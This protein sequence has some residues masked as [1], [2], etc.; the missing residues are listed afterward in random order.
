MQCVRRWAEHYRRKKN[1]QNGTMVHFQRVMTVDRFEIFEGS[2]KKWQAR[3][4]A[5]WRASGHR[6]RGWINDRKSPIIAWLRR[7]W[8]T[9]VLHKFHTCSIKQH[10]TTKS[11]MNEILWIIVTFTWSGELSLPWVYDIRTV[12]GSQTAYCTGI[13]SPNISAIWRYS[14]AS[15]WKIFYAALC[16]SKFSNCLIGMR[17]EKTFLSPS[18]PEKS[19]SQ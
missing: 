7:E 10:L 14:G 1:L 2:N 9:S 12:K 8:I 17:C 4:A 6:H 16:T 11:T 19:L 18:F 3:Q 5:R 13:I 15:R